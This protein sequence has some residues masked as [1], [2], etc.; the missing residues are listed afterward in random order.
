VTDTLPAGLTLAATPAA[1]SGTSWTC[2]GA[3]GAISFSC[4]STTPIGPRIG[5]KPRNGVPIVVPVAVGSTTKLGPKSITNVAH[6]FGGGD[7]IHATASS[8]LSASDATTVEL[9]PD[10]NLYVSDIGAGM[11]DEI[12]AGGASQSTLAS[13][14]SA[15][16]DIAVDGDGIVYIADTGAG[17]IS[18]VPAGGGSSTTLASGLDEPTGV[19]VDPSGNVYAVDFGDSTVRKIPA[20]GGTPTTV[21]SGLACNG[22]ALDAAGNLYVA[23]TYSNAI[24]KIPAGGGKPVAVG[25]GFAQPTGVAVDSAGNVYVTDAGNNAVKKI[26]GNTVVTLASNLSNLEGI[27]VD[28]AG[29]VYVAASGLGGGTDGVFEIPAGSTVPIAVGS[30]F[31]DPWGVA[32]KPA[33]TPALTLAK[34]DN[35]PWRPGTNATPPQYTIA[36]GNVGTAATSGTITVTDTLPAGLTLTATPSGSGWSCTG[37][38][39]ATSFTCSSTAAIAARTGSTPA[40]GQP[41]T[42]PVSIGATTNLGVKSITNVAHAFGGGDPQ[43]AT[44]ATALGASDAT[45]VELEPDVN[46]Y[47]SDEG[48]GNVDEILAGG[49]S[50]STLASGFQDNRNIA[51]DSAGNVYVPSVGAGSVSEIPAAGGT[52]SPL[53]TR[54]SNPTGV[55]VDPS[56]NVYVTDF[57]DGTVQEIP[58]GGGT[59]TPIATGLSGNDIARDAAGNLYVAAYSNAIEKIPAGGGTP[60]AVGSG[61]SRPSGVAVDSAGNVYVADAG[62]DAVKEITGSTIV[63]LA[64]GLS[65]LQGIAVDAAFNVYVVGSVAGGADSVLE[66]P[67]GSSVPIVVSSSFAAPWGVAVK[68]AAK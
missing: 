22:I 31:S 41:I 62:N 21:A 47:V 57:G 28:A 2:T 45:T 55:A 38:A 42:V 11:L 25:S 40:A 20:G 14:L 12:A 29:N 68:P 48:A 60:V 43:H 4:T 34:T 58:A 26:T 61:F 35:G 65:N 17:T 15:N 13:G 66:I 37:S 3:V 24:E 36:V 51:V 46:L 10:V 54:L 6:A 44:A 16:R 5:G 18:E 30:G 50:Q 8:A 49:T 9:E 53:A 64:S 39:G 32:V 19:A 59:P 52:P 67:A 1:Q 27:A 33:A 63:T 56:G 23:V 7:P